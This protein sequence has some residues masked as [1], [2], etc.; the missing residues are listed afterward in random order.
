MISECATHLRIWG[1]AM[2][3]TEARSRI[4]RAIHS[5]NTA[6]ELVVRKILWA[7]GYRYR[8]HAREL[9]GSPDVV[10][11]N[12]RK[13]IFVHGCFWHQ[14]A[15]CGQD[16]HPQT[17]RAF[18]AKKLTRNVAR[19]QENIKLLTMA[20]WRILVVWECQLPKTKQLTYRLTRFLDSGELPK[21]GRLKKRVPLAGRKK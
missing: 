8:L 1:R 3:P 12:L 16:R 15:A 4:M 6:P 13:A 19:D 7:N 21:H 2:Q 5:S 14:H 10:F 17:N 9:P 11:R 20:G 18:W